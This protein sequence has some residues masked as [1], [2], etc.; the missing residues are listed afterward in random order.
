MMDEKICYFQHKII[1]KLQKNVSQSLTYKI[2]NNIPKI[3]LNKYTV[4]IPSTG[5]S[6]EGFQ[7]YYSLKVIDKN[8]LEN[9]EE[10]KVINTDPN[11]AKLFPVITPGKVC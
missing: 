1:P 4:E 11:L 2:S 5:N 10:D 7:R 6:K 9:L 3:K 8:T